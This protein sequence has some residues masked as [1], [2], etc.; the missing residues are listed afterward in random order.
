MRAPDLARADSAVV[1]D[2]TT[3]ALPPTDTRLRLRVID[4][5]HTA[6][7]S[8]SHFAEVAYYLMTLAAWLDDQG[9]SDRYVVVGGAIWPGSHQ[10][11]TLTSVYNEICKQGRQPTRQELDAAFDADLEPLEFQVFGL[12]IRH[13]LQEDLR[14]AL[15]TPWRQL[16]YHVMTSCS[17][18][19]Y[20]GYS[21]NPKKAPHPDHCMPLA[22]ST[23]DLCQVPQVSPGARE[24]L[25]LQ[26][27]TTVSALSV[28]PSHASVLD[29]H[30]G[31]KA[32]RAILPQR[33]QALVQNAVVIPTSGATS[34]SMPRHANLSIYI[35]VDFDTSSGITTAFGLRAD[36]IEPLPYGVTVP[37][38][39]RA[40]WPVF[41]KG[42]RSARA[43]TFP[44]DARSV[45]V[46]ERELISFLN[47]IQDILEAVSNLDQQN[48][49]N[50]SGRREPSTMQVYIWDS[51]QFRH[52]QR[53]IGRHL[54]KILGYQARPQLASLAWLFPP[55][56]VLPSP[57]LQRPSPI[58]IVQEAVSELTALPV[59]HYYS[60]LRTV[61]VY[62][63]PQV[64][65]TRFRVHPLFQAPLSDQI[66]SERTHEIWH[67]VTR[68]RHWSQLLRIYQ[69][70]VGRKLRALEEVTR[71]LRA[72]LRTRLQEKAP[73]LAVRP[74]AWQTGMSFD[75]Q[76]WFNYAK[77]DYAIQQTEVLMGRAMPLVEREAKFQSARL[78]RQL[79]GPAAAQVLA[80][81]GLP[82]RSG[83]RVYALG[84]HSRAVK[85]KDG[86]FQCALSLDADA[87]F[88]NRNF[89]Y[90]TR[91]AS[92]IQA[93]ITDRRAGMA[94]ATAV[95]IVRLDRERGYI[96]LDVRT[97]GGLDLVTELERAG[98]ADFR[99][100]VSLDPIVTD[101]FT[102]KLE[103]CL[104]SIGN[105]TIAG[106]DVAVLRALGF[107]NRRGA[108]QA[109]HTP[110]A[111]VLWD[112]PAMAQAAAS[113][114]AGVGTAAAG[115]HLLAAVQ[116]D[117]DAAGI[118]LTPTQ[119]GAWQQA[120]T[121]R[122]HVIWG[123]PGTGKSTVLRA[124]IAGAF[125][126]ACRLG[127]P[128]RVLVCTST[129]EALDN[130]LRDTIVLLAQQ[131]GLV[132]PVAVHRLR[133]KW[134][135]APNDPWALAVDM[136][137]NLANP[138]PAAQQLAADL[139]QRRGRLLVGGTP[140]QVD[141][142]PTGQAQP[143][144]FD[145]VLIDEAS[146]MDVA[147]AVLA[148][149]PLSS[150]GSVILAG[151]PKQLPAIHQA[152]PPLGLESRVGSIYEYMTQRHRVA[153]SMLDRN[154]RANQVLVD[155]AYEAGYGR[156]LV[157]HSPALR[158]HV[159]PP[160]GS[161]NVAPVDWPADLV[162][163][164]AWAD[165]LDS[166]RPAICFVYRDTRSSQWN[167]FEV[168]SVAALIRTLFV[169]RSQVDPRTG[170]ACTVYDCRLMDRP[171]H[172]LDP[173]GRPYSSSHTPYTWQGFW[174][175]G[176]GVV[177]PH[178]AQQSRLVSRLQG[179]FT[180]SPSDTFLIRD[181]VDTVE[182]FQGQQRDIII[183]TYA[184][185]DPDN[186]RDE[187]EFLMSLNR[188]NVMASRAR[189]KFILLVTQSVI[190]H[191]ASD[192][193]A[194]RESRLLKVFVESFCGNAQP[195]QLGYLT[196]GQVTSRDG[197]LRWR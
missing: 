110:A 135:P 136:E 92:H 14:E 1:A 174:E 128:L 133:S 178:R 99:Q 20:L 179:L 32:K 95:S 36:W 56:D 75:G 70:T 185:G 66:P 145:L 150:H 24:E 3:A 170:R 183:G 161:P 189:A 192:A 119:W 125:A 98:L 39:R 166:D 163:F 89:W 29:G 154:Y 169:A 105:P 62:H 54:G 101:F 76:L 171:D 37:Q 42:Q 94:A 16:P 118:R 102:R 72:Q 82:A 47:Q 81:Y 60:L 59:P 184:L 126:L 121:H 74:P 4:I 64:P 173:A 17:N 143:E 26:R 38:R 155:F 141:N 172:E 30:Q 124:I 162:W 79:A 78:T 86:D 187:E 31:L 97:R 160:V 10:A 71:A 63:R 186:I 80:L 108:R 58:T 123:P 2:G 180:V 49:A 139:D 142:L 182:K 65:P 151:D 144:L 129:Y 93:A 77:L 13:F 167:E 5:K 112:A 15:T 134:R 18:C 188:F 34:A 50:A 27:I 107:T 106:R 45:A 120:L 165:M 181:A 21:W 196:N 22:A 43:W 159:V 8:V 25:V 23:G 55:E 35:S 190:D 51:L 96:V 127:I 52:L 19:E 132:G 197:F 104:Q 48:Q 168:D 61:A 130:V 73:H 114:L 68:P 116:F 109:P 40:S 146:Q 138:T 44:V 152:E 131:A 158:L 88:L 153:E 12:R 6:E 157:S 87:T 85:F 117:L 175:S 137:I 147:H 57:Q 46:E 11:S 122:L 41:R 84:P 140:E 194:L 149:C 91:H 113:Y 67:R 177:T 90:F 164:P 191:L 53:V 111:D 195:L 100:N 7:P 148:F 69:E 115:P 103:T 9:L 193:D 83:R 28:L 176:V 33:A 156:A